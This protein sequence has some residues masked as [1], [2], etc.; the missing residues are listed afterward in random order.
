MSEDLNIGDRFEVLGIFGSGKTTVAKYLANSHMYR[1]GNF[2][3][4]VATTTSES[5]SN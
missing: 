2:I 1:V 4:F 5:S 3:I